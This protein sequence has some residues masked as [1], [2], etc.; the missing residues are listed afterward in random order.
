MKSKYKKVNPK[1]ILFNVFTKMIEKN[2]K[3]KKKI[4]FFSFFLKKINAKFHIFQ[5]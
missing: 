2:S 3:N 4:S 1:S 5:I